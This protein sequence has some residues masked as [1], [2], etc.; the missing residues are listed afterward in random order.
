MSAGRRIAW[1]GFTLLEVMIGL[2]LLG[3]ALTVLIKSVAG[4]M[5]NAEQARMMGIVTDLARGQMYEIEEK[6]LKEGFSDTDQ[7]QR[8]PK[9]FD[10][11]GWPNIKYSYKVEAAEMP[12]FGE[13][14]QLAQGHKKPGVGSGSGKGS[15]EGSGASSSGPL[16]AFENSALGGMLSMM[17]GGMLGG[18]TLSGGAGM[19]DVLGA[20][21][22]ALIQS[23]YAMFQ[24][25]LKV[26][27]RKVTLTVFYSVMGRSRD[28]TLVAFYSDPQ[29]MD[30]VLSGL[31]SV[32]LG[33]DV[34]TGSAT[35]AGA[36]GVGGAGGRP[37]PR[38]GSGP[39]SGS[40]RP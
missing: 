7:S 4:N 36:A 32:D 33:D 39:S 19:G 17:G 10:S 25:I 8:D 5:F 14:Q 24:Q 18:G 34:G 28:I 11:Q 37:A 38:S 9:P 31:G 26:S 2:S 15:N 30:K 16:S 12:A 27:V 29:A 21:G 40:T 20:Q 1:R 23:Q 6:L 13:L 22:G 35:K 3:L